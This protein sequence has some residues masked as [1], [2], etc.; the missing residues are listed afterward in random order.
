MP[1]P[2]A[3]ERLGVVLTDSGP[4]AAL[5]TAR[6][7]ALFG[8]TVVIGARL[9]ADAEQAARVLRGRGTATFGVYLDLTDLSS[10][11]AFATSAAYLAGPIDVMIVGGPVTTAAIS[12]DQGYSLGVQ[13]LAAQL[14][15]AT[16]RRHDADLLVVAY[17]GH[18]IADPPRVCSSSRFTAALHEWAGIQASELRTG[19]SRPAG[20]GLPCSDSAELQSLLDEWQHTIT[21]P[22]RA[23]ARLRRP[24]SATSTPRIPQYHQ[25]PPMPDEF[26]LAT[27]RS[28]AAIATR[29]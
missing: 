1:I 3:D 5:D 29:R 21:M 24:T 2:A 27:A 26:E 25:T 10:V 14:L 16:P 15:C 23:R 13:H 11:N 28:A 19:D 7:F 18:R 12:D 6:R 22:D 20:V 8:H 9:A 4:G 17:D